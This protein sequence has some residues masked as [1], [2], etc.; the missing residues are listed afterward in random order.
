MTRLG[1]VL[2]LF[3]LL[4]RSA[5]GQQVT[6]QDLDKVLERADKLLEEAKAAYEDARNKSSVQSFVEA[7]FKLEDA[8]I[9]YIVLQEIGSPEK[10]K[11][12]GDR[13]RSVNQLSKLIHD[14]KVAI[15]GTPGEA[16]TPK[17]AEPANPVAPKDTAPAVAPVTPRRDPVDVTRRAAV[18]D[19]AKQKEAEKLIKDLFKDQY[20][21]K[22]Q[23]DRK[24]L[25]RLLLNQVSKNG[26]DLAAVWVLCREAQDAAIQGCD[27]TLAMAT[28]DTASG[29]FDVDVLAMRNAA[30][31][32][33]GKNAKTPEEFGQLA[34]YSIR[35]VDELIASDQYDTADKLA[36][37]AVGYARKSTIVSLFTQLSNRARDIVE[38]KS[39][40]QGMKSTLETLAKTP[41]D[42]SA[43]LEMGKF[44]C[45]VKGSWD[46]GLRFVVKGSDAGLKGLAERELA[47]PSS[48]A[49]LVAIGDLWREQAEKEKSVLR[50]NQMLAHARALYQGALPDA[51]GL[52]RAKIE[53]FLEIDL[54]AK[55]KDSGP[56]GAA[57]G[58]NLLALVDLKEDVVSG[59]WK[60]EGASLVSPT[61]RT[62][63]IQ[64][65]YAPP[66]E[67]DL[68][69]EIEHVQG[70]HSAIF[71]VTWAGVQF[72]VTCD[73]WAGDI[74][75]LDLLDRKS[76]NENETMFKKQLFPTGKVCVA[77]CSVRK[78]RITFT[79][80]GTKAIDWKGDPRRLS[81]WD[82]WKMRRTDTFFFGVNTA[83]YKISKISLIEVTGKGRKI[84]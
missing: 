82:G 62:A 16:Q 40:Y 2:L 34:S 48:A 59:A 23:S 64:V 41:D 25:S 12:A 55:G 73:G 46:L 65:P 52:L 30:I 49:E 18:P 5:P 63:R 11:I 26:D 58:I 51:A 60:L 15:T 33:A 1:K 4:Y 32:A 9:K 17:P 68:V 42:P 37:S 54:A 81:L 74:T 67:Y 78:D 7:G 66:E 57:K 47:N 19:A 45:F 8:R 6:G 21:K 53:K 24:A 84:R 83:S 22:A 69:I 35:V 43:N 80:D 71:G 13:L 50:K 14:G 20:S 38:A 75:G 36:A 3:V 76:A 61:E 10:Q 27:I 79:V 72:T 39:L 56:S 29:T 28:I 77:T 44:L 70:E 31:L